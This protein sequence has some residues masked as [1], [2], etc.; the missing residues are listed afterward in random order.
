[1]EPLGSA[2]DP[3]LSK[4][5]PQVV[6]EHSEELLEDSEIRGAGVLEQDLGDRAG[7]ISEREESFFDSLEVAVD[8]EDDRLSSHMRS[9]D[10]FFKVSLSS[11]E[12]RMGS[13]HVDLIDGS[14]AGSDDRTQMAA[15]PE[16][17][18]CSS[19][20]EPVEQ[21]RELVAVP[22]SV[23]EPLRGHAERRQEAD[24]LARIKLF[25]TQ[26]ITKLAPP[27]LKEVESSRL[28]ETPCRFTR[29]SGARMESGKPLK[30]ASAA[31]SVLLKALGIY[32]SD[33]AV[34][35][36]ALQAFKDMF[37]VPLHDQHLKIIAAI[38]RKVVP[39]E[40]LGSPPAPS[41]LEEISAH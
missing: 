22:G 23:S 4:T 34:D 18:G 8:P 21:G 33:L 28:I 2:S 16:Q 11:S 38:F 20:S 26:V 36:K 29:S 6:L 41:A 1:V 37:D 7:T 12:E 3:S 5:G 32:A 19:G 17:Q 13:H 25:C 9:P 39:P 35:E 40:L 30:H 15:E 31:E 27:L 10:G 24:S 14:P